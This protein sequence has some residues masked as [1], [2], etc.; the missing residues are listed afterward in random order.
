MVLPMVPVRPVVASPT[1][2]PRPPTVWMRG[3]S[4]LVRYFV[5]MEEGKMEKEEWTR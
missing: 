5:T 3:V 4:Q 2:L 1:V